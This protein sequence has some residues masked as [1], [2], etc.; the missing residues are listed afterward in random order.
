MEEFCSHRWVVERDRGAQVD[1]G[2]YGALGV[3]SFGL[4]LIR[5]VTKVAQTWLTE[6]KGTVSQRLNRWSS[7]NSVSGRAKKNLLLYP[8]DWSS[9]ACGVDRKAQTPWSSR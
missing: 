9:K 3:T 2:V 5:S 8:S 1:G 4:T 7:C 6:L